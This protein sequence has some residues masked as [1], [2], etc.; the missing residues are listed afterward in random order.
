[1]GER[2]ISPGASNQAEQGGTR[3]SGWGRDRGKRGGCEWTVGWEV[4]EMSPVL[5]EAAANK[6]LK[7]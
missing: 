5:V 1:M 3:R 7:Q 2:I 4:G 6:D